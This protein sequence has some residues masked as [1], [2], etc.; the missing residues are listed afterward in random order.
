MA[1]DR[2]PPRLANSVEVLRHS[3]RR[4]VIGV[5]DLT[6]PR[7]AETGGVGDRLRAEPGDLSLSTQMRPADDVFVHGL[8]DETNVR[9]ATDA[10]ISQC[11]CRA[12]SRWLRTTRDHHDG[13][14]SGAPQAAQRG[15]LVRYFA[16][17][18]RTAAR[19]HSRH[20]ESRPERALGFGANA[21]S[22]S[23]RRQW[24]Q[25][26]VTSVVVPMAS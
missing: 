14:R 10:Q 20:E 3:A 18:A 1:S 16:R 4:H 8:D 2:L 11:A 25:V 15:G 13:A 21:S 12:H 19:W 24:G 7:R 26:F 17:V 6:H 23:S 5:L 22:E 9:F